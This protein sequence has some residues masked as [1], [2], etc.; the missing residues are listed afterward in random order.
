M[1]YVIAAPCVADYSCVDICPV[2]CIAPA[3]DDVAFATTEQLYINPAA[4]IDCGACV[5]ACLKHSDKKIDCCPAI[6]ETAGLFDRYETIFKELA[7]EEPGSLKLITLRTRHMHNSWMANLGRFRQGGQATNPLHMCE[8]DAAARGIHDGDTVRVHN[9]HGEVMAVVA[10]DDDLRPGTVALS[11][12]YGHAAAHGLNRAS[13][14][15][16][17]NCNRLT[18]SRLASFEPVSHMAWLSAVPVEVEFAGEVTAAR[19]PVAATAECKNPVSSKL[20][21]TSCHA[22]PPILR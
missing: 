15:P 17:V 19:G 12:G 18:P 13:A 21:V 3:P 1:A 7:D 2:N 16:G 9:T 4:C 20:G 6:F 8:E 14:L 22:L 10:I 5:D 11:H